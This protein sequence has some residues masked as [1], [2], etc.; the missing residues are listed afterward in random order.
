MSKNSIGIGLIIVGAIVL[1]V[2]LLADVLGIGQ[3][4]SAIGPVQLAGVAVGLVIAVIGIV[5][6]LRERKPKA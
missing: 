3:F 5:L 2:S 1:S 6:V 4:P